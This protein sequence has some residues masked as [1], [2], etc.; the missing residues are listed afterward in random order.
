MKFFNSRAFRLF[1]SAENV[2]EISQQ[3]QDLRHVLFSTIQ[4]VTVLIEM[5]QEKGGWDRVL[6]KELRTK[7]MIDDHNSAGV[8]PWEWH[9]YYS[10]TLEETEFLRHRFQMGDDEIKRFESEVESVS[11]LT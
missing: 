3:M 1:R 2:S 5:L 6:Y 11:Q 7:R 4:D 10:Y 8:S 9:S